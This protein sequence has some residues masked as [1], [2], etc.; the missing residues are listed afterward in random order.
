MRQLD[1]AR[2]E[3]DKNIKLHTNMH[4]PVKEKP[5]LDV[6]FLNSGASMHS[7][8]GDQA[9]VFESRLDF[10]M[11]KKTPNST[12]S[13]MSHLEP[14]PSPSNQ[15]FNFLCASIDNGNMPLLIATDEERRAYF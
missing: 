13:N 3:S 11:A 14:L 5:T 12:R 7:P 15:T 9:M 10:Q 4:T 2:K 8:M 1:Q 6:S